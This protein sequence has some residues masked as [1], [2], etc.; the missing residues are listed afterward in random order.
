MN[1]LVLEK[2]T[3]PH[4]VLSL[5]SDEREILAQEIRE[6]IIETVSKNGGHLAPPLGTVELTIALHAAF[7]SPKDRLIW[8]VGHQAYPHK[9]LTGR[10]ENF[11]TLRRK[12]G[13]SGFLRRDESPH[14]FFG[15]GH[16]STAIPAALGMATARDLKGEDYHV[17]AIVGDGALTGGLAYEGLN[18]T[19]H[20]G[21]RVVIVLNDNSM[22]ISPNVGSMSTYLA[23]LRSAPAFSRLKRDVK[24]VLRG[25]PV[26]G[27]QV[28]GAAGRLKE[29]I[30][31]AL[32]P[33]ALFEELGI[34]Y[35]GP[36]DGHDTQLLIGIFERVREMTGP[37]LVH[38]VTQKG[39]GYALAEKEPGKWHGASPFDPQTGLGTGKGAPAKWQDVFGEIMVRLAAEDPRIVAITAAMADG[40]GLN[41][42]AKTYPD[43]F[44]DVGIAE[45]HG[46]TFAGGLAANGIRPVVAIY[47]TFLQR[48]YDQIIHD[49]SIQKLPVL[50]AMD[51]GGLVGE[52]GATHQGLYDLAYL[53]CIPGMTIAVPRDK[54]NLEL[55][56]RGGLQAPGPVAVRYPRGSASSAVGG[57]TKPFAWGTGEILREGSDGA[58]LA[59]GTMVEAA[60][61]AADILAADGINLSVVDARFVKPLDRKLIQ[62]V[63]AEHN[64][65]FTAEEASAIGGF[66]DAILEAA[67]DMGY[68]GQ[69][70]SFGVPDVFIEHG[71]RQENLEESGLTP[72]AMASAIGKLL[73]RGR[74]AS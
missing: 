36:F 22:S 73:V 2:L 38:V 25:I 30:K 42:F 46:V 13:V 26:V 50:F 52:D 44:F 60:L 7:D 45:A 9:L 32:V 10:H 43:R 4:D 64:F 39:K 62:S 15:A 53:R 33:G 27:E 59:V 37:V 3:R 74:H 17:V 5:S 48:A 47:S 56:L 69:I 66:G 61:Q 12:G 71:T 54:E 23:R 1:S 49:I 57:R 14:D 55:I 63:M 8:D 72:S 70:K 11:G 24:R 40:T 19:G 31:Y 67:R 18:N 6:K 58:I 16:A 41:A 34:T 51:R 35:L 21:T 68:E 20:L 29:G 65:I 28:L